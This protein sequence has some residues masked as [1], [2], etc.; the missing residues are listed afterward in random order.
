MTIRRQ[1]S[2][3]GTKEAPPKVSVVDDDLD[4]LA[5]FKDLGDQGHFELIGAYG[6]AR[7]ALQH[8]PNQQPDLVFMDILLP[9][10]SGIECTKALLALLPRLRVVVITGHPE[11]STLI[12]AAIAGA[13]GFL[14]KPF[15]IEDT[16]NA[17]RDV[18]KWGGVLGKTALPHM[19]RIIHNLRHLGADHGLSEREEAIL[20]ALLR[21]QTAKEISTALNI[22]EATVHTHTHRLFK[23]LKVHSRQ[24]LVS[25]LLLR[26]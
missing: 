5:F 7:E 14:V 8:L 16:L 26:A 3:G 10:M 19:L 2:R 24:E 9:D 12:R 22:G 17:I 23:K 20:A 6:S 18:F 15:S 13:Q 21:G 1:K 4:L 25:K 11:D